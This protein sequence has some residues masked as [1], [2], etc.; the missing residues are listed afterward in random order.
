MPRTRFRSLV[1][2]AGFAL[3]AGCDLRVAAPST[4]QPEVINLRNDFA[5]QATGLL[6]FTDDIQYAWVSDGTAASVTQSP[7]LL[8]G[9]AI[10]FVLDGAGTQVYQRSLAENGTFAT[11]T[12]VPGT[13]TVRLRFEEANGNTSFRLVKQ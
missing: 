9:T 5:L 6:D 2:L 12:G 1:L 11:T 7:T 3:L 8:T 13:W 10:L 4:F